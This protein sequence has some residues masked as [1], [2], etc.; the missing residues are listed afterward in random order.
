MSEASDIS[1]KKTKSL[2]SCKRKHKAFE[3][4]SDAEIQAASSLTQLGQK[5]A[6]KVV[7]KISTANI[8]RVPS[9]FSDDEI[10]DEPRPKGF[11]SCLWCNL[12]FNIRRNYSPG[13]ENEL[14]DVESFSDDVVEVE[15]A[16]IDS[17][18]AADAE[19]AAPQPSALK[20]KASPE[21]AKD[22]ERTVQRSD[23]PV[24][25]LP[26]VETHEELPEGQ[27]PSPSVA[28]FNESFGTSF[29]GELLSVSCEK[30][31]GDGGASRLSLL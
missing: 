21:F 14:V 15:K 1:S 9:A 19:G 26:L 10:I 16:P 31:V 18:V 7:K 13:S 11:S 4:T 27:D 3:G 17:V 28:A 5:R 2:E 8:R 24:D 29:R 6:K 23:G 30:A 25:N 22:L 20:D 12:R